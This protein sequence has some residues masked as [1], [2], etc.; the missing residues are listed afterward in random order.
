LEARDIY[1]FL[2]RNTAKKNSYL[3]SQSYLFCMFPLQCKWNLIKLCFR[4]N[5][6]FYVSV[7]IMRFAFQF[8]AKCGRFR[9]LSSPTWVCRTWWWPC[10]T[11]SST[12][13]TWEIESGSLAAS[14]APST[15]SSPSSPSL[16][17]FWIWPQCQLTG[18]VKLGLSFDRRTYSFEIILSGM[19]SNVNRQLTKLISCAQSVCLLVAGCDNT[20]LTGMFCPWS[21]FKMSFKC[22]KKSQL[23]ILKLYKI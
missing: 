1:Y 19:W 2:L 20:V 4:R 17:A 8:I 15:T 22:L 18:K 23:R 3:K 9:M 5:V 16:Q 12:T 6:F 21:P 13:F 10:S 7:S 11:A 14:I